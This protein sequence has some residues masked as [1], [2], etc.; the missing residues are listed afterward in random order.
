MK[1]LL[2]FLLQAIA[3]GI[4]LLLIA[5][6]ILWYR[7]NAKLSKTYEF[8]FTPGPVASGEAALAQGKHL[9][10]TRGCVDCHGKDFSGHTVMDNKPM[11]RVDGPNITHGKGG[12]P[13]TFS[14]AD[15]E[16]AIRHGVGPDKRGL[17]LMPSTDYA[18]YSVEDMGALI[19]YLKSVPS[20]DHVTAPLELGP[21]ARALLVFGKIKLSADEIDHE[22]L[23][24]LETAPGVTA[25]YGHYVALSC[26]GCHGANYSGGKIAS[27]PPDW[28]PAANLTPDPSGNL[29][30]WSEADFINTLRT[31]KRPDGTMLH[32]AMPRAFGQMTDSE[33]K[34][35]WLFMKTLPA[36]ATGKR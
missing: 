17:Y 23:K 2:R 11:G 16:R 6:V 13:A 19:A 24:P 5:S 28:P 18:Q 9:A 32:P 26:T 25:D 10:E 35:L 20:V 14:D 30:K 4:L 7:S 1:S 8:A 21:I 34:A 36:A 15:W 31:A 27:G 33:L 22:A 29:S 3:L 12:L